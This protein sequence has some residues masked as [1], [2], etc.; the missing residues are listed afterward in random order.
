MNFKHALK[1]DIISFSRNCAQKKS[2][3]AIRASRD[4]S[5]VDKIRGTTRIESLC[6]PPCSTKTI[7]LSA[8]NVCSTYR[9][10]LLSAGQLPSVPMIFSPVRRSQ[11]VTPTSC[12]SLKIRVS[13]SAFLQSMTAFLF[14]LPC[15][16]FVKSGFPPFHTLAYKNLFYNSTVF[17]SLQDFF[18]ST[19]IL[20]SPSHPSS[21]LTIHR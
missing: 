11:S 13:F 16:C 15:T 5:Y 21:S 17:F 7:P 3:D 6:L 8:C 19:D 4:G 2:L 10:T 12:Q 14:S 1:Q 18:Q 9:P 20:S